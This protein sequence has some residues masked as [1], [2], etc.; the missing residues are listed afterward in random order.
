VFRLLPLIAL[1]LASRNSQPF[2]L[3]ARYFVKLGF[4]AFPR[5]SDEKQDQAIPDFAEFVVDTLCHRESV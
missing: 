5:L 3:S 2:N 1:L 4:P